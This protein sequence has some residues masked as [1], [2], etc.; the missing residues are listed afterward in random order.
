MTRAESE[1]RARQL[2]RP[3][4]NANAPAPESVLC[5]IAVGGETGK[6]VSPMLGM[7]FVNAAP[8]VMVDITLPGRVNLA[9][10][11]DEA[12][13]LHEDSLAPVFNEYRVGKMGNEPDIA[14][15]S[16]AA[17]YSRLYSPLSRAIPFTPRL[18]PRHTT[19][20]PPCTNHRIPQHLP[21]HR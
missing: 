21:L 7:V 11:E 16:S 14:S 1:K 9:G 6:I 2:R 19:L 13:V 10:S 20:L 18:P 17:A 5:S 12:F 4:F 15:L 8:M 3:G